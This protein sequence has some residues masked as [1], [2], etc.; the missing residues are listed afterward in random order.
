MWYKL[1]RIMMRPNGV[2]KQVRPAVSDSFPALSEWNWTA[3]ESA[4][5]GGRWQLRV[6]ADGSRIWNG[7][8]NTSKIYQGDLS[9][10]YSIS[11]ITNSINKSPWGSISGSRDWC[12]SVNFSDDGNYMFL[13]WNSYVCRYILTTPFDI[14][15]YTLDQTVLMPDNYYFN[16]NRWFRISRDWHYLYG[17]KV[18]YLSTANSLTNYSLVSN[19]SLTDYISAEIADVQLNDSWTEWYVSVYGNRSIYRISLSTPYDFSTVV[20]EENKSVWYQPQWVQYINNNGDKYLYISSW[21]GNIYR[22]L[23]N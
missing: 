18:I 9:T 6:K 17:F 16:Q 20:L 22:Y 10:S 21:Y 5:L 13:G 2:E 3:N 12:W 19:S 11:S 7:A 1:K 8:V 4:N 15:S 14:N 23:L